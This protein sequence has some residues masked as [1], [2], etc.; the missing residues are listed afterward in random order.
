MEIL[1]NGF[2]KKYLLLHTDHYFESFCH[3]NLPKIH[4][5]EGESAKRLLLL[6]Q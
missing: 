3:V 4:W 1:E 6:S 2:S 5:D